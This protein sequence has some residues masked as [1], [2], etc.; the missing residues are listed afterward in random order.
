MAINAVEVLPL[1]ETSRVDT[2]S[3][4]QT[5]AR[6]YRI[7][8]IGETWLGS[9]ARAAFSA[10]RRLGNSVKVLDESNYL[11][12]QWQS[13]ASKGIRR[14]LR[15]LFVRELANDVYRSIAQSKPDCLFVFK[16]NWVHAK[17]IRRCRREGIA[18]INYYPDVS[19]LSHGPYIPQAL[20]LYDHVFNTKSYGVLDMQSNLAVKQV[21]FLEPGY[22]PELHRPLT[23][24]KEEEVTYGCEVAFIGTWSPKKEAILGAL[25]Q[26]LPHITLRIW[27][28]Q[29]EKNRN[30]ALRKTIMG[31]GITGDEYTKA[32]CGSSVCLGLLSEMGK[33]SSS[34]DLITAR[35]F[36]IPACGAFML[37]ERNS[38][39]LKYFDEGYEAE[40][41]DS[42]EELVEKTAYYLTYREKRQ[43]IAG[44]G[45]QR[46]LRE[47]Y[48]ID[49]RMISVLQWLDQNRNSHSAGESARRASIQG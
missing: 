7:L 12:L 6:Q 4:T 26:A 41:F 14:V 45:L 36:Q 17:I 3:H 11:R 49:H 13:R 19:F 5:G 9:D 46:S 29:W 34:G 40:F 30:P 25:C 37:H 35:T 15:P 43:E 33:G 27:G 28:N 31:Y 10:L 23:L 39:V 1:S 18:T 32:I 21:S 2:A 8:C 22:D 20:P 38:E 47:G 48:A 44:N 16:G 24:T 42:P